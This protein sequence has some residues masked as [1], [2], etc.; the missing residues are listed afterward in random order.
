MRLVEEDLGLDWDP[1]KWNGSRL[2]FK[3]QAWRLATHTEIEVEGQELL[4]VWT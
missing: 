1:M 4:M 2:E 3:I